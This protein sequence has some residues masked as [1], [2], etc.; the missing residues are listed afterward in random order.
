MNA[1]NLRNC[2]AHKKAETGKVK[3][4]FVALM[5]VVVDLQKELAV[6]TLLATCS[7]WNTAQLK[8]VN[9]ME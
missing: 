2:T 9:G 8:V 1:L 5:F 4:R 7:Q 3:T 6:L